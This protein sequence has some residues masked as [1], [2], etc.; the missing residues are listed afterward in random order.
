MTA[1]PLIPIVEETLPAIAHQIPALRC[2][3]QS[4]P[5]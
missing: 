3:A 4:T 1:F 2:A 5:Q